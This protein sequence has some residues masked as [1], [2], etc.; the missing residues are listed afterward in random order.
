MAFFFC[1][2]S[3][4]A[5]NRRTVGVP[6]IAIALK[7]HTKKWSS[8]MLLYLSSHSPAAPGGIPSEIHAA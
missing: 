5:F 8:V 4:S 1:L 2:N 7:P 3:C 6:G